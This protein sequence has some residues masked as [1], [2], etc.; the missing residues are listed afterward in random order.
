V[1]KTIDRLKTALKPFKTAVDNIQGILT[2]LNALPPKIDA[3][4]GS[5]L[6][7]ARDG[8]KQV[9]TTTIGDIQAFQTALADTLKAIYAAMQEIVGEF[10]PYWLLNSF[11]ES[12]FA[13]YT[14]TTGRTPAGM[15][16]IV[17]R[18]ASGRD[19]GGIPIAALLQTKLSATQLQLLQSEVSGDT[20]EQGNRDNVISSLNALLWDAT[21]PVRNNVDVVKA[22]LISQIEAIGAK[23]GRTV[24]ETKALYRASALLRLVSDAWVD[25]TSE[26][27]M[28][29]N[30]NAMLRL[31]RLI[32]EAVY[33]ADVNLGLQSLHAL[34][35]QNVANLYPEQTVRQLDDL[36]TGILDKVK[37]LPD[38]LI[39]QPLDDE[40]NKIKAVLKQNFDISGIFS[41]LQIKLDHIDDD[42]SQGL[43]R[44][45]IAYNHL[46]ATF[47]QRLSAAA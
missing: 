1:R 37:G 22:Q 10:S 9:I 43:D 14:G 7:A 2:T 20:L 23:T 40:F 15:M 39:R 17:R 42:L 16:A 27:D 6:D 13:G 31:N 18:I 38:L 44:L 21:L 28:A 35:V 25:F 12:D 11:S 45:S 30:T 3:A 24:D 8:I 19:T 32:V 5:V 4:V 47:D 33:T 29:N 34:I 41:V 36:Y 46:L 26:P